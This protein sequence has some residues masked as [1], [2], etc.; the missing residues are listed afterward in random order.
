MTSAYDLSLLPPLEPEQQ[1]GEC[2][3]CGPYRDTDSHDEHCPLV[4][5]TAALERLM[6]DIPR[7]A[8]M[9]GD[10]AFDGLARLVETAAQA[11]EAVQEARRPVR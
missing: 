4:T 8:A 9:R 6:R 1:P 5:A 10:E 3:L 2:G 11:H 7:V